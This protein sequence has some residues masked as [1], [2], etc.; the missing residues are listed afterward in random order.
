MHK[1]VFAKY[2]DFFP[3]VSSY[4]FSYYNKWISKPIHAERKKLIKMQNIKRE[5]YNELTL[6]EKNE[7]K[8]NDKKRQ[9]IPTM[10]EYRETI[11]VKFLQRKIKKAA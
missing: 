8:T 5:M 7:K 11:M 2:P 6:T 3:V 1:V 4:A 10:Q 9:P